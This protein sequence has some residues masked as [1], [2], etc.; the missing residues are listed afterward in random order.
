VAKAGQ[1]LRTAVD[2]G[3]GDSSEKPPRAMAFF[4]DLGKVLVTLLTIRDM[5]QAGILDDSVVNTRSA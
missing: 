1:Q 3:H 2:A 5:D 4:D